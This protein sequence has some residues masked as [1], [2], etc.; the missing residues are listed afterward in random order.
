MGQR[1]GGEQFDPSLPMYF[2]FGN[3]DF[4]QFG[5]D[6]DGDGGGDGSD[7]S[8]SGESTGGESTG[9]T[10]D[11]TTGDTTDTGDDTT[12]VHEFE[13]PCPG[14]PPCTV[15]SDC[16]DVGLPV[17]Q[18]YN[19][20]VCYNNECRLKCVEPYWSSSCGIGRA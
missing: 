9:S 12:G 7:G 16:L 5:P 13:L 19:Y 20:P 1:N 18:N 17:F 14:S 4:D 10:G 15:D 8:T 3:N 2:G 6:S 11:T